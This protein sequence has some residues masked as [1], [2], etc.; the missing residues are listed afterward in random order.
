MPGTK[1]R[2]LSQLMSLKGRRALVTGGAGHIGRAAVEALLEQGARVAVMD[3]PEACEGL[4]LPRT[5]PGVV[6]APADIADEDATHR[7]VARAITELGGLDILVHCAAAV[8]VGKS[9][10][11]G[12]AEPLGKQTAAAFNRAM[13]INLT[14]AFSIVQQAAPALRRSGR[15]SVVF[16]SSIYGVVGPDFGLYE[17]T[18]MANPAGYGASKGG[19]IQLM[20]Y[21]ATALA[22]KVRVNVISP[23]GVRRGQPAAF[24]T[25]YRRKT[26]LKRMAIEEDF[27]GAVAYLTSDMASYV[28]GH[29]LIVDGGWTTW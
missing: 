13:R 23:G 28:T 29:N 5:S 16:F 24:Q 7:A 11:P 18:S 10:P 4:R 22:P 25:R 15:G 9:P 26:P 17:G 19:L 20:R 12:W 6:I 27:K 8:Y 2:S 1:R 21:F 14:A 3:L